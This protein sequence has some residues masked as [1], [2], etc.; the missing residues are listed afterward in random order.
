MPSGC[1]IRGVEVVFPYRGCQLLLVAGFS[2]YTQGNLTSVSGAG[3]PFTAGAA[4]R[5]AAGMY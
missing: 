3:V 1:S 5:E 4:V 2:P